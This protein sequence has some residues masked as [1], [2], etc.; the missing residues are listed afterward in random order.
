MVKD[1]GGGGRIYNLSSIMDPPG[2]PRARQGPGRGSGGT[3]W[4][5][6]ESLL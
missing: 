4:R 2:R 6:D 1:D 3:Y 5:H